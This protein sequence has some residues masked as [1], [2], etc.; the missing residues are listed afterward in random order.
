MFTDE[1]YTH[2][3]KRYMDTVFRVAF[4]YMKNR[5][6]ADDITQNVLLKLYRSEGPFENEAHIKHWLI[7]VT[8]NECKSAVRSL[9]RQTE[10]LEDYVNSL[11][12]PTQEHTD[13]LEAVLALPKKY[14]VAVYL[15]Y[16]EG[17]S[18]AEMAELLS[19]PEATV[20]THL[21]RARAKLKTILTEAYDYDG[22]T[23][24]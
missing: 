4:S 5:A 17:Y 21:A 8:I 16:Y 3:A 14:R 20:R 10:N 12:M 1:Q 6:D 15:Y 9:W 19:L 18:T 24:F 11:A 2:I 23:A 22:Q 7:R 13:L